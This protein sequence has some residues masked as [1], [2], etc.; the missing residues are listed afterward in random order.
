MNE[1]IIQVLQSLKPLVKRDEVEEFA[2][3][4]RDREGVWGEIVVFFDRH[5]L[6]ECF[7]YFLLFSFSLSYSQP[8]F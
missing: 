8:Q 7:F 6:L 2:V 4:I 1:Y 3:V 5:S